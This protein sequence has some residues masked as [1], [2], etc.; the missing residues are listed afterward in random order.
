MDI[1]EP[2]ICCTTARCGHIPPI[3]RL[4]AALEAGFPAGGAH[5]VDT[6][7]SGSHRATRGPVF[8]GVLA[9]VCIAVSVY[10]EWALLSR[11]LDRV[12]AQAHRLEDQNARKLSVPT[13]LRLGELLCCACTMTAS[14]VLHCVCHPEH[15]IKAAAKDLQDQFN[16]HRRDQ[17][18]VLKSFEERVRGL[19]FAMLFLSLRKP[20]TS[21]FAAVVL[22][23]AAAE[24]RMDSFL[25]TLQEL[26]SV[27]VGWAVQATTGR[28]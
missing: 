19:R 11:R 5:D 6:D 3:F 12:E 9:C 18:R 17:D 8:V 28:C 14:S 26:Q 21:C 10:T 7:M 16:A 25:K 24:D 27:S 4:L 15:M 2:V 23:M 20:S 22:Q 13:Q 1:L